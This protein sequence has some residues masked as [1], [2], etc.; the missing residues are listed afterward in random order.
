MLAA[1]KSVILN[2]VVCVQWNI[3]WTYKN[4]FQKYKEFVWRRLNVITNKYV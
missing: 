1:M 3:H 2:F 4:Q